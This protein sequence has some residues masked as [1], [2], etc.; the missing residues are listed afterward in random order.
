L[1]LTSLTSKVPAIVA[2]ADVSGVMRFLDVWRVFAFLRVLAF[3]SFLAGTLALLFFFLLLPA[4]ARAREPV[5]ALRLEACPFHAFAALTPDEDER[6]E[7]IFCAGKRKG[8]G[9][10]NTSEVRCG[11]WARAGAARRKDD[12]DGGRTYLLVSDLQ[13]YI[14][15]AG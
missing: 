9:D 5:E 1:S 7:D 11:W 15:Y 3:W 8:E 13:I 6:R 12:T 2:A 4:R 14:L 10:A